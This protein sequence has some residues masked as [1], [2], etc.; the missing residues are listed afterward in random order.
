VL[1]VLIG[2]CLLIS[3]LAFFIGCEG[4]GEAF[5]RFGG[6]LALTVGEGVGR[7]GVR[8]GICALAWSQAKRV[9]ANTRM[10]RRNRE[11]TLI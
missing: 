11:L 5:G 7:G 3:S 4:D 1:F 10:K 6:W 2:G 9:S 8:R